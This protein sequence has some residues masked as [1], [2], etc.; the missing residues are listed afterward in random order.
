MF[1]RVSRI[2]FSLFIILYIS[3]N[4]IVETL[5]NKENEKLADNAALQMCIDSFDIYKDKIIR[6]QDS[7][8][9]GA[10]YLNEVDLDSRQECLRLCCETDE[11]D[12]F[13]FEEKV[14]NF[15]P[16]GFLNHVHG[17]VDEKNL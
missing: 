16:Y 3:C 6:T 10:K 11:C 4:N 13:I 12:V 5:L 9:L 15:Y 8:G 14:K 17:L 2:I 7:Q 1:Y